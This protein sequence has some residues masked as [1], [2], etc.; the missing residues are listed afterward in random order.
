MT[1]TA[2]SAAVRSEDAGSSERAPGVAI[3]GSF[4]RGLS[5]LREDHA[6]LIAAGCEILSPRDISF[7]R[8]EAGF[9]FAEHEQHLGP[10]EIEQAH[11]AAIRGAD[12]VWLHTPRGYLGP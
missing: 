11:L 6:A 5:V 9:V 8:E 3:C 1:A 7:V 4:R 12:F 10:A 2:S